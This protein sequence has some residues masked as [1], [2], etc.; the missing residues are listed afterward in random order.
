MKSAELDRTFHSGSQ[1]PFAPPSIMSLVSAI[2]NGCQN[3]TNNNI[4]KQATL[5]IGQLL[6]YN[7]TICTRKESS[8]VYH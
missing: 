8:S 4:Y 6:A 3:E 2:I 7:I 1:E 5:T